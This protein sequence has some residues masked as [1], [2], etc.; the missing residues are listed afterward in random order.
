MRE[1]VNVTVQQGKKRLHHSYL[2]QD[3]TRTTRFQTGREVR[4]SVYCSDIFDWS[5]LTLGDLRG[6]GCGMLLLRFV[7]VLNPNQGGKS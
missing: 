1:E 2:N 7:D 6:C 4:G 5:W 3:Y